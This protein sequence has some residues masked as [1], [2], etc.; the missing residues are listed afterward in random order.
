MTKYCTHRQHYNMFQQ[1]DAPFAATSSLLWTTVPK[2]HW[3]W[4]LASR[5]PYLRLLDYSIWTACFV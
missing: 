4:K 2:L 3:T 1:D 5:L